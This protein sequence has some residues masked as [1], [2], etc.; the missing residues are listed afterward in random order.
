MSKQATN[1][2]KAYEELEQI[3]Q[4]FESGDIDVERDLPAF[5][6]GL[7]LASLCRDR[8]QELEN[9]VQKIEKEFHIQD[10]DTK[11]EEV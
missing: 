2:T 8:L 7:K 1:F 10:E 11:R 3:V 9:H 6:R 5:E 4:K